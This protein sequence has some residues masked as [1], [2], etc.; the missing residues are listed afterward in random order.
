MIDDVLR[1][2][3]E[4]ENLVIPDTCA[5]EDVNSSSLNRIFKS[6]TFEEMVEED[7]EN[8]YDHSVVSVMERGNIVVIPE[9]ADERSRLLRAVIRRYDMWRDVE[10]S[11]SQP[12]VR[13]RK[14]K[15]S[16]KNSKSFPKRRQQELYEDFMGCVKYMQRV[17]YDSFP[18]IRNRRIYED[19][20]DFVVEAVK[21]CDL[22]INSGLP[23]G[24]Y[25][26]K[27]I[28]TDETLFALGLYYAVG[29]GVSSSIVTK[30][31][32]IRRIG[33]VVLSYLL[34]LEQN[35]KRLCQ[36][37]AAAPL[38]LITSGHRSDYVEKLR[39]DQMFSSYGYKIM[40]ERLE[41]NNS[42]IRDMAMEVK[43]GLLELHNSI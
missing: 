42:S 33:L 34:R 29:E 7:F 37:L 4:R 22:K 38:T 43:E 27:D 23:R 25:D 26:Y 6:A 14:R 5:I 28:N 15:A 2:A 24:K 30:D 8:L 18:I 39:A 9:V 21:M 31:R 35:D 20:K 19:T 16:R 13:N 3:A 17:M 1:E 10:R 11:R 32:D 41:A 12:P 40:S 36:S